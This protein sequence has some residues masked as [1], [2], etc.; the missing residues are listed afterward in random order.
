[1]QAVKTCSAVVAQYAVQSDWLTKIPTNQVAVRF[2]ALQC[3]RALFDFR[4]YSS[5]SSLL[6]V[7]IRL[8]L[9]VVPRY[10]KRS[11]YVNRKRLMARLFV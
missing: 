6:K 4:K 5:V 2:F 8:V 9:C 1:M 10:D 7:F 3:G 11:V